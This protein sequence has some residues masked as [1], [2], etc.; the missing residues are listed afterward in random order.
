VRIISGK[1][2]GHSL[3]RVEKIT[4]R[5]TADMVKEAVFNM[6]FDLGDLIVLD[7]FA[8]SGA[9]AFESLS[10]GAKLAY[11]IDHDRHAIQTIAYNAKKLK[12]QNDVKIIKSDYLAFLKR[13]QSENIFDLVFLDPPYEMSIY[14]EVIEVL[15]MH[16]KQDGKIVCEARKSHQFLDQIRSFEKDKEKVYGNKKI[17]I[18][19]KK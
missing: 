4:T 16:M 3:K 10:R 15:D 18:Y 5:E 13:L 6:L 14:N 12:L 17:C 1:L 2:K 11:L 19:I 9:Y 8:G 7:L